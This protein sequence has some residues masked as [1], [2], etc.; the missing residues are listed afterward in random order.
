MF[1]TMYSTGGI[2]RNVKKLVEWL[3]I[4]GVLER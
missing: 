3:V 4:L 2:Q 1:K